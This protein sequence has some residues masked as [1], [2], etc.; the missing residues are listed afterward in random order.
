MLLFTIGDAKIASTWSNI[1]FLL[2]KSLEERGIL[3]EHINI[4]PPYFLRKW[5]DRLVSRIIRF[6][7]GRTEY[8]FFRS[9][10]YDW[11]VKYRIYV[12]NKSFPNSSISFF[13]TFNAPCNP[14][15]DVNVLLGD[16]TFQYYIEKRLERHA[17][18][19]EK[20]AIARENRNINKA[21]L[22]VS[23]FSSCATY[24]ENIN[25]SS[26]I[27]HFSSNVVNNLNSQKI[28]DS[29]LIEAKKRRRSILFVGRIH[30]LEGVLLLIE[31]FE[32]IR[33]KYP[34][35]ELN[36][37]GLSREE[38]SVSKETVGINFYGFLRKEKEEECRLYYKLIS[39]ATILVNPTSKWA[40]Y[41]SL[42]EAMYYYTPIITSPFEDFVKEFGLDI[43]FGTYCHH[44]DNLVE[45]V[46]QILK[47]DEK[48]YQEMCINA[49]KCVENH[50]WEHYTDLLLNEIE[51]LS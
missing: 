21:S 33:K 18:C 5:F 7:Y 22:V 13:L 42:I 26:N 36:I 49:H 48:H 30:Y 23:L 44:R 17:D 27:K 11:Y 20:K 51:K 16:W 9:F 8:N 1:P 50:T 31:A 38:V 37:I 19:F 6:F 46:E 32:I 4:D 10:V 34:G 35:I 43:K 24:I 40:G 15:H 12:A 28:D 25:P 47:Q 45:A 41:S 14:K 39:E 3:I 29:A 2:S